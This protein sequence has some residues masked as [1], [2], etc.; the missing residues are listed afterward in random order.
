M[1]EKRTRVTALKVDWYKNSEILGHELAQE[2]YR[3]AFGL[4]SLAKTKSQKE[5]LNIAIDFKNTDWHHW[6]NNLSKK[7]I[8]HIKHCIKSIKRGES[9]LEIFHW[10]SYRSGYLISNLLRYLEVKAYNENQTEFLKRTASSY[11]GYG[12]SQADATQ[13][14][15][16]RIESF[17]AILDI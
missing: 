5:L 16:N 14:I 15:C 4:K 10:V 17:K 12:M 7:D 1:S 8:S 2:K 9:Y 11:T 3:L 6:C 13:R